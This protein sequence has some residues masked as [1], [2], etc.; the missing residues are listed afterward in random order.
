MDKLYL[1]LIKQCAAVTIV[2]LLI[3]VPPHQ[4]PDPKYL[5]ARLYLME[6]VHG[7]EF[8]FASNPPTIWKFGL[9]PS[10]MV[11]SIVVMIYTIIKVIFDQDYIFDVTK[12]K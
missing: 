2:V 1:W 4:C 8:H 6:H 12:V 10:T 9:D 11:A 5:S 7:T 3:R